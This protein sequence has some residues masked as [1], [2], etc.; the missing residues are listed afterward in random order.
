MRQT[1]TQP[2]VESGVSD[3][4]AELEA[5]LAKATPGPWDRTDG[6]IWVVVAGAMVCC[7]QPVAGRFGEAEC[8]GQPINE[9]AQDLIA[10]S[11]PD[12]AALI[13]AAFNALPA[14]LHIARAADTMRRYLVVTIQHPRELQD[15]VSAY[16]EA[17]ANLS[18]PEGGGN[19]D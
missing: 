16:R 18:S 1:A 17:L 14:L 11:S 4:L 5:L 12:T 2:A 9:P 13:V 8:C 10:N 15:A 19:G 6:D 3:R 7:N